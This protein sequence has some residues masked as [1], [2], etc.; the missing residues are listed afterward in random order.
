MTPL[1]KQIKEILSSEANKLSNG[2]SIYTTDQYSLISRDDE[3]GLEQ[4]TLSM[5]RFL[6]TDEDHSK[7]IKI[8]NQ[9]LEFDPNTLF[10]DD[11]LMDKFTQIEIPEESLSGV[12]PKIWVTPYNDIFMIHGTDG[13][14]LIQYITSGQ[15]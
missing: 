9:I 1:L 13:T 3:S 2:S 7:E 6:E 12:R 4:I 14:I 5:T 15:Y 10:E 8:Y 11:E